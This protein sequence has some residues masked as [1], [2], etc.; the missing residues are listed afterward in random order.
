MIIL[1][2]NKR[3]LFLVNAVL[4]LGSTDD[5]FCDQHFLEETTLRTS[6]AFVVHIS[7][8]CIHPVNFEGNKTQSLSKGILYI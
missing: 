3:Y 4:N 5:A 6:L 7:A 2:M 1:I 8:N